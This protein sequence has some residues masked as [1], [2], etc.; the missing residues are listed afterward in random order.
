MGKCKVQIVI[1]VCNGASTLNKCLDSLKNQ[2]FDNWQAILVD[3]ASTDDS[4]DIIEKYIA[5][6]S[7]FVLIKQEKNMGVSHARNRALG[8]LDAEYV[9]F[10][11][12]DD[13][14]EPDML[15][16][17]YSNAEKCHCDV[18]QCRFVYDFKNGKQVLP[19][20]AFKK[21]TYLSGKS[22]RKV[23]IRMM[24]GI[25]MNHVCIKLIKTKLIGDL[26][27]DVN[28]KT[29]ED[30]VFCIN[31][32]KNVQSYLFLPLPL[33]HYY[34]SGASITGKSLTGRQKL[35]ANKRAA[36]VLLEALPVWG[37]NKLHYRILTRLRAYII[38]VSKIFRTAREKM[39]LSG[40]GKYDG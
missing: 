35:E 2:T 19:A 10:L 12:C 32:F 39:V 17:M 6:D 23:Y 13:W 28:M 18:V 5:D 29:A 40:G 14:W 22:L 36:Q 37:I 1:P 24:T 30:L 25:N 4:V 34:R 9:A 38:I 20:G 33:Y 21:Q 11:D 8:Q 3:D 15:E 7:R 26:R 16:V 27:F 31:L